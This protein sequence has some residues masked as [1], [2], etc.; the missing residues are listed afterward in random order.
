MSVQQFVIVI[1]RIEKNQRKDL[2]I[3]FRDTF[4]FCNPC[5]AYFQKI[6]KQQTIR[7]L[8]Y[9]KEEITI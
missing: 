3:K 5:K 6:N 1:V 9:I 2:E 8:E 7:T 4:L